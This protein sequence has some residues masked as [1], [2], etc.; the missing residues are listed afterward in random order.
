MITI[1]IPAEDINTLLSD[2]QD[3]KLEFADGKLSFEQ[4]GVSGWL[5][6]HS[7]P[8][9]L[10]LVCP[11]VT[12][13]NVIAKSFFAFAPGT[14]LKFLQNKIPESWDVLI[15]KSK[16]GA[17]FE[18]LVTNEFIWERMR[19]NSI[20]RDLRLVKVVSNAEGIRLGFSLHERPS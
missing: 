20:P 12:I 13:Q 16:E 9:A 15:Q 2:I 18:V 19:I 6:L 14:V 7:T 8:D 5:E 11:K 3:I 17:G 4:N 1:S 10:L